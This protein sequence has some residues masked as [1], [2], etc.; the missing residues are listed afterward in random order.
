MRV[1][2]DKSSLKLFLQNWFE[3]ELI[4]TIFENQNRTSQSGSTNSTNSYAKITFEYQ[5]KTCRRTSRYAK[6]KFEN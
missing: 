6:T 4:E 5:S 3:G 1:K 2:E